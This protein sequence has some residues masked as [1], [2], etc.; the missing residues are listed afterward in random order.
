MGKGKRNS[1]D[2]N[3]YTLTACKPRRHWEPSQTASETSSVMSRKKGLM[4]QPASRDSPLPM[5]T[6]RC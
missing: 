2:P 5:S 1:W 3:F 4:L 6:K